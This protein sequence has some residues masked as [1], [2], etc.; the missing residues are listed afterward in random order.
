LPRPRNLH[1]G[2]NSS[3][4]HLPLLFN[5]RHNGLLLPHRRT[6]PPHRSATS[7]VLTPACT[8]DPQTAPRHRLL[9]NLDLACPSAAAAS[10]HPPCEL[11]PRSLRA[12]A[13]PC[14]TVSDG[15][16]LFTTAWSMVIRLVLAWSASFPWRRSPTPA[17]PHRTLNQWLLM[18]LLHQSLGGVGG[19]GTRRTR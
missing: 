11:P 18:M 5:A 2:S 19:G 16:C 7:T 17:R 8:A 10:P 3:D 9:R 14:A 12:S 13:S 6:P 4:L 15:D 1:H